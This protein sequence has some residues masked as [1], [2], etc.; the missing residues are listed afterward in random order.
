MMRDRMQHERYELKYLLDER[1]ALG[2]REFVRGFL[3]LD[4]AG[5]GQPF[6]SYR[7]NSL[8]L[9]S[10]ALLTFWD[11]INA[12]RNRFKLRM[13]F[14]DPRPESPVFLELKRNT[15]GCIRKQRCGIRKQAAAQVLAGHFPPEELLVSRSVKSLVALEDILTL[16]ARLEL[17]P[18]ALVTY[19]R[20]AYVHPENEGVRVTLD[21]QVRITPRHDCRFDL[22]PDHY[23]Q[24]FGDRVILELK[25]NHRFP[26]W[27]ADLVQRFDLARGAAAKYCEGVAV[28]WHPRHAHHDLRLH[29]G[30]LT[31]PGTL[32]AAVSLASAPALEAA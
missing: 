16:G 28:L 21:R 9:D 12:N 1:Q 24:P 17:R 2:I 5:V 10:P 14:Y 19:L 8:Y 11:W 26:L 29:C 4:E 7:V 30:P 27:F 18:K 20:E 23:A 3:E 22:G 31:D 6:D 13:R 15:G 25:F 32:G